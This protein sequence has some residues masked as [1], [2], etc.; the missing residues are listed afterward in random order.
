MKD[1]FFQ[2]IVQTREYKYLSEPVMVTAKT[3][4]A[5]TVAQVFNLKAVAIG[6]TSITVTWDDIEIDS[7]VVSTYL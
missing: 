4:A 7:N 1:I 2:I 3:L 5:E 6:T